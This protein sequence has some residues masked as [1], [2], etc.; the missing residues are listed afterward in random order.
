MPA[1]LCRLQQTCTR[2]DRQFL[3]VIY[4]QQVY[5]TVAAG[6]TTGS[7]QY[8]REQRRASQESPMRSNEELRAA[9]G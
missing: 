4:Q 1:A 6:E 2:T 7:L 8:L 3:S 9:K 5:L